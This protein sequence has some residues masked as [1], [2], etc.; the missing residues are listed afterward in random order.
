MVKP[1]LDLKLAGPLVPA[2][3]LRVRGGAVSVAELR[4]TGALT[5]TA[6]PAASSMLALVLLLLAV[7]PHPRTTGRG[8]GRGSEVLLA[9][10]L[11]ALLGGV[12][13]LRGVTAGS[14]WAGSAVFITGAALFSL[15]ASSG[16]T[17]RGSS[18]A[19]T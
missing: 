15:T 8:V 1:W 10:A 14:A 6:V 11:G 2:P 9:L 18:P 16:A 12:Q 5:A 17:E 4:E 13:Q 19:V 3:L 7:R